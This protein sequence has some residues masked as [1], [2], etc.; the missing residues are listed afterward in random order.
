[1]SNLSVQKAAFIGCLFAIPF[2]VVNLI[3]IIRIQPFYSYFLASEVMGSSAFVPLLLLLLFPVGAY[4]SVR[5]ILQ[6]RKLYLKNGLV[7]A[8]L[9]LS[10][11]ILF[12]AL[13]EEI[14]RCDVLKIPN[15]D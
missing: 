3:V 10:F 1:M 11:L 15:C 8:I 2:L 14:Y 13:G 6:K 5:P 7:A 4:I 9:L 12:V